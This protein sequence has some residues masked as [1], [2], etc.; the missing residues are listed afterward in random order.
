MP[1]VEVADVQAEPE[2]TIKIRAGG[3]ADLIT[4]KVTRTSAAAGEAELSTGG[5]VTAQS[6]REAADAIEG[7]AA[8]GGE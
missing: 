7:F 4:L 5:V 8:K 6:L 3:G 2:R 1:Q